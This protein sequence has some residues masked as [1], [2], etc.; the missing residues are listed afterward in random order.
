[1]KKTN[2]QNNWIRRQNNDYFF[3]LS[4]KE[5]YRSRAAYKLIEIQKK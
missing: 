2:S 1:M 5:G 4:K 3:N